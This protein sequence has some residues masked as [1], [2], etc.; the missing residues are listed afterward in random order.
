MQK[1]ASG[2]DF[3]LVRRRTGVSQLCLWPERDHLG[4]P[5]GGGVDSFLTYFF[6]SSLLGVASGVNGLVVRMNGVG[7]GVIP[8]TKERKALPPLLAHKERD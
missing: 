2:A 5:L 1:A 7:K 8:S 3:L 6:S 4:A